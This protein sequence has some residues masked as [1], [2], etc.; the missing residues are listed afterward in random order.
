MDDA[1]TRAIER[2]F[3][4]EIVGTRRVQDGERRLSATATC[5]IWSCDGG[6]ERTGTTVDLIGEGGPHGPLPA[7]DANALE[8]HV[9]RGLHALA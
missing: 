2:R 1:L 5:A 6:R 7:R 9:R 4:C 3:A 8:A